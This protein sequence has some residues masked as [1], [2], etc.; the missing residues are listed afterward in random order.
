LPFGHSACG[1]DWI[2][3]IALATTSHLN[4]FIKAGPPLAEATSAHSE[5]PYVT[6]L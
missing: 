6:K 5:L 1:G 3:S 2:Q 4:F